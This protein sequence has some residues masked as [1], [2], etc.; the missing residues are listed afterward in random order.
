MKRT[1]LDDSLINY[2]SV[3]CKE[4][5]DY[6]KDR[7]LHDIFNEPKSDKINDLLSIYLQYYKHDKILI[8][9]VFDQLLKNRT[10][11]N[12]AIS[13]ISEFIDNISDPDPRIKKLWEKI[14]NDKRPFIPQ[15]LTFNGGKK[16]S[17]RRSPKRSKRRSRKRS[18]RRSR[19]RSKRR[20]RK[21]SRKRSLK[22]G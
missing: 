3:L 17:K 6:M 10:A 5:I 8:E 20:S 19:K 2:D 18:K 12:I 13:A 15:P 21:R 1:K 22:S 11:Q 9:D 14:F 16:R 4:A 7:K